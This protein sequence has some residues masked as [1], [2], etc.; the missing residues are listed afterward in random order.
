MITYSKISP[1]MVNPRDIAGNAEEE[2]CVS[3][4]VCV[5]VFKRRNGSCKTGCIVC[6]LCSYS[7]KTA[8][9]LFEP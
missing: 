3:M 5:S 8:T 1:K 9:V 2:V 6:G 4:C 7:K